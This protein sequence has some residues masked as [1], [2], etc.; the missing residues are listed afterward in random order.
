MPRQFEEE[1]GYE[2]KQ[3][4]QMGEVCDNEDPSGSGD[5]KFHETL[6]SRHNFREFPQSRNHTDGTSGKRDANQ[7]H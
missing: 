1:S 4:T 3:V 5:V 7:L 2:H 6:R